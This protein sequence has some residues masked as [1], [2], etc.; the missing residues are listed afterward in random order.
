MQ[1][2]T[3]W[4]SRFEEPSAASFK[5]VFSDDGKRAFSGSLDNTAIVW[6][7]NGSVFHRFT[8]HSGP[9]ALVDI[10]SDVHL[11]I[12]GATDGTTLLWDLDTGKL[13]RR[14]NL[15]QIFTPIFLSNNHM[16]IANNELWRIDTTL[17]ELMA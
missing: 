9:I 1:R 3:I 5:F 2:I 13:I 8:D 14:Y 4:K 12:A 7:A 16:T 17:D 11:G 15:A 6:D 10:S